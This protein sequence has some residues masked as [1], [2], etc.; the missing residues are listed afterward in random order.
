MNVTIRKLQG[1]LQVWWAKKRVP[2]ADF[3]II[4]NNCWGAHVYQA[5][6]LPYATPFVGLFLSPDAY[7][8]LLADFPKNLLLPL[9]F[10]EESNEAWVNQLREAHGHRWP[11][12][13]LGDGIEIQFMHYHTPTEARD[14]WQRRLARLTKRPDRWFFKFCDRDGYTAEYLALFE[15]LPYPNK[16]FFT[17]RRDCPLQCAVIIPIEEPRVPHGQSLSQIS[18]AYFDSADWINGGRG[19]VGWLGKYLSCV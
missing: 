16:V 2:Q 10:K 11:I 3:S 4:S 8:R 5:V 1:K 17:T 6:N 7:L 13:R 9:H 15:Q 12:G 14:K 18:P 19:R